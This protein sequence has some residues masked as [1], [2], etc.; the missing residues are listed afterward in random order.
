MKLIITY[1]TWMQGDTRGVRGARG[2]KGLQKGARGFKGAQGGLR[3]FQYFSN[4]PY[5]YL[6]QKVSKSSD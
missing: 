1:K 5:Q 2:C 4:T 6:Y 3:G